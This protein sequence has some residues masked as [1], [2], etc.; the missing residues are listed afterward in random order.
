MLALAMLFSL[1]AC[2]NA[3]NGD[4]S[5]TS[6]EKESFESSQETTSSE[7][8]ENESA[9]TE[10]SEANTDESKT[11]SGSKNE[12]ESETDKKEEENMAFPEDGAKIVLANDEVYGWWDKY[13]FGKTDSTPFYRHEDIYYPNSVTFSWEDNEKADYYR[14]F[15]S[16]DEDFTAECTESYLVNT[17]SLTLSH[18]FT[19]TKYYWFV[20]NTELGED[21]SEFNLLSVSTRSFTTAESPRCI[22]VEGVSNTRDIGGL[23]AIDGYRV[24]QGMIYRGGKLEGITEAGKEFFLNYLG[25]KTDLDLRTPGEGGAGSGSPLGADV[26]YVNIN[27]RYYVGDMGIQ[28]E[29][30]KQVFAQEIRL[31]ADPDNYPIYIHCSL[32]RDRT[33][34]LAMVIE[35]LLGVNFNDLMKDYEIS[36]FSVTGTLDG[37]SVEGIRNNIKTTYDYLNTFDGNNF[38][39]RVENYLLSIGITEE[40]IRTIRDLLLEEVK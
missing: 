33:G 13:N 35:G 2:T 11:D 17:N 31:F 15:I 5:S 19:G 21:G 20:L 27:G 3:E 39:E 40:E 18:L 23:A 34:T 24:K 14:L 7:S 22:E 4:E 28:S 10:D 30:G 38:S 6:K 25:L 8:N 37:A 9:V 12:S 32:G 1:V 26:N 16:T 29:E 36:V